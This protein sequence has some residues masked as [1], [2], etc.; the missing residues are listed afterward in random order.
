MEEMGMTTLNPTKY[1]RLCAAVIPKVIETV[2]EFD[3][4]VRIIVVS[5][6]FCEKCAQRRLFRCRMRRL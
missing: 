6:Q 2:D 1:G 4:V 3:R 5:D